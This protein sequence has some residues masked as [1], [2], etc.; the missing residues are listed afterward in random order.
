M[1]QKKFRQL[2]FVMEI[3]DECDSTVRSLQSPVIQDKSS[4]DLR[5]DMV[6]FLESDLKRLHREILKL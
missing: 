2:M 4:K 1:K 6:K 3:F 5:L